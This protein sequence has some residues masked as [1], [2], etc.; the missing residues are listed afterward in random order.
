MNTLN[1]RLLHRLVIISDHDTKTGQ[2]TSSR[3]TLADKTQN[4]PL[5]NPKR[6]GFF[7]WDEA[8]RI[9]TYG[10][11]IIKDGNLIYQTLKAFWTNIFAMGSQRVPITLLSL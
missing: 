8:D 3:L 9:I 10:D 11:S 6:P 4:K 7:Q 1:K 2:N 5:K